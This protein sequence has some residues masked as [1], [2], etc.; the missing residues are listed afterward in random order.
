MLDRRG[1]ADHT[2]VV[3]AIYN[4]QYEKLRHLPL[5]LGLDKI[6]ALAEEEI[7]RIRAGDSWTMGQNGA[8]VSSRPPAQHLRSTQRRSRPVAPSAPADPGL[9]DPGGG[10]GMMGRI[11]RTRQAALLGGKAE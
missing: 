3:Q 5:E 1:L 6:G 9:Q 10:L 2:R 8:Q 7:A 4:E 11:I